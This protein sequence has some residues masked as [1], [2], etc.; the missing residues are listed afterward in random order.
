M[1]KLFFC[2]KRI[3]IYDRPDKEF[4]A[5]YGSSF[6]Q[7]AVCK[8]DSALTIIADKMKRQ[9]KAIDV[10]YDCH[11]KRKW[12]W[13][14]FTDEQKEAYRVVMRQKKLG[15]PLSDHQ[16][17]RISEGKTGKRG[18][19]TGKSHNENT[20]AVMSLRKL[21]HKSNTGRRWCHDPVNGEERMAFELP[22]GFVWGRNPAL[23]IGLMF[24]VV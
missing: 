19:H 9:Y 23:E 20:K 5:K 13:K 1:Y 2:D 12:G 6:E 3:V 21:G 14:Y 11:I 7:V 22:I 18:N 4:K 17:K 24:N 15:K 16:K 10:V 8:D